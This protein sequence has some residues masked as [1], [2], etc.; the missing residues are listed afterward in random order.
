MLGLLREALAF[1][2][3]LEQVKARVAS[4]GFEWYPY[5]SLNNFFPIE[6]L[7]TSAG[8]DLPGLAAGLPVVDVG[9]ADGELAFFLESLGC[10]VSVYDQPAT[11]H[12]GMRGVRTLKEA[13]RST[14]EILEV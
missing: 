3:R 11:N 12:N 5:G 4:P 6:K 14:I 10:Q 2:D 8:R 7:L 13:L 1:R 9:C